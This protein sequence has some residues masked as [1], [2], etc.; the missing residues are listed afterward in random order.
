MIRP[1]FL[2]RHREARRIL[3]L[4]VE[5]CWISYRPPLALY[6]AA[7]PSNTGGF[8]IEAIIEKEVVSV[9][10]KQLLPK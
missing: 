7:Y 1:P 6:V 10:Y 2:Q 9:N 5:A 4:L 3:Y 8:R